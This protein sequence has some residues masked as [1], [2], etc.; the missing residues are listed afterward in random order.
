MVRNAGKIFG[1]VIAGKTVFQH[2]Y[3]PFFKTAVLLKN[4][5]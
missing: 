2:T 3:T 1:L 4:T 5:V